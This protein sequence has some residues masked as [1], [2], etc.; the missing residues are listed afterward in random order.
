[1]K[2]K[3]WR[4]WWQDQA[5]TY[6]TDK[7]WTFSQPDLIEKLNIKKDD[8]VLEIGFGYGREISQFCKISDHVYGIELT[9]FACENTLKELRERGSELLPILVQ[10]DGKK[11][12]FPDNSFHAIYSCFV[13]QHLSRKHAAA[14]IKEALK[15]L[16][17]NGQ[18]LFE[19][20]GDPGY[21]ND[22]EDVFSESET[23]GKMYNNAYTAEELPS[24]VEAAGGLLKGITTK[25]I[26]REWGNHWVFIGKANG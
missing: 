22:G 18:I 3:E 5:P 15:K 14:L 24:I 2:Y 4:K 16:T 8:C 17:H 6:F 10:Y 13:I 1:M 21:Y 23:N 11:I 9:D 26:T 19:F 25:P 7:V 20:F 12:P